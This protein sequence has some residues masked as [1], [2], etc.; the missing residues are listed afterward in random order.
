METKSLRE[1]ITQLEGRVGLLTD[2]VQAHRELFA[3]EGF[4]EETCQIDEFLN[5]FPD[6]LLAKYN[7]DVINTM[8][9]SVAKSEHSRLGARSLSTITTID[10]NDIFGYLIKLKD[11]L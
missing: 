9:E 10:V 7:F 2:M 3:E 4:I 11:G 5:T 6:K 1:E 8:L